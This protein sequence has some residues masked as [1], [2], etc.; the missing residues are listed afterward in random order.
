MQL[1]LHGGFVPF[2]STSL[3]SVLARRELSPSLTRWVFFGLLL[4]AARYKIMYRWLH[5]GY[6]GQINHTNKKARYQLSS[7]LCLSHKGLTGGASRTRTADL[8]IMIPSL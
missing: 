7:R 3:S 8:W 1:K 6:T 5:S 2:L 4:V